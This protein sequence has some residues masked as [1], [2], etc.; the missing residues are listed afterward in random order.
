MSKANCLVK[1]WP[2]PRHVVSVTVHRASA[3]ALLA[4]ALLGLFARAMA[5]DVGC[6]IDG[7]GAGWTIT[8]EAQFDTTGFSIWP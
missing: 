8:A 3:H 4:V 6:D 5:A 1:V 2:S 7:D